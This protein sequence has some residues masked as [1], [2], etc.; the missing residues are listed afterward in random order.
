[1][2]SLPVNI[3]FSYASSA[4][5]DTFLFDALKKHLTLLKSLGYVNVWYDSAIAAGSNWQK[6]VDNYLDTA[7]IIVLLFSADFLAS[8]HC[9]EVEMKRALE[10]RE[11]GVARVIY[12]LLRPVDWSELSLDSAGFLPPGGNPISLWPDMDSALMEVVKGIKKVV[13]ELTDR[14][15]NTLARGPK[16][17]LSNL[18]YRQN[19][20]F[21]GREELLTSIHS[22]FSAYARHTRIQALNGLAGIGKTEIAIEYAYRYP[23]EY[24]AIFWIRASSLELF[25]TD[26]QAL[27]DLLLLPEKERTSERKLFAAIQRYLQSSEGWLLF[28]DDLEDFRLID[29]LIPLQCKGHVLLTSRIQ[30]KHRSVHALSVAPMTM[31]E[32]ALFLL[33][34]IKLI[35]E[36][37]G[38]DVALPDDYLHA[39][40]VA[41]ALDGFPLVLDQAGAYIEDTE[42][43]LSHYLT[44]YRT[45]QA[46]LL[47][48]RGQSSESHPESVTATLDLAFEQVR[49]VNPLA[50]QLLYLFAFLHFDAIPD[51]MLIQGGIELDEPLKALALDPLALDAALATL[52][53]FSLVHGRTDTTL[54]RIHRIV[55]AVL[56]DSLSADQQRYWVTMAVRLV[57]R[58]FPGSGFPAWPLYQRYLAQAQCCVTFITEFQLVDLA[59]AQLAQRLG[60]Y[61]SKRALYDEARSYLTLAIDLYERIS[62]L[63]S[64]DIARALV[65]QGFLFYKLGDYTQS[66]MLYL[67][68]LAI[69]GQMLEPEEQNT[70]ILLNNLAL[71]YREQNRYQEAEVLYQ[72]VLALYRQIFGPQHS[73]VATVLNNLA[74]LYQKQNRYQ[75]AEELYLQALVQR[76]ATLQAGNPNLAQSWNNLATLYQMQGRYQEAKPLLQRALALY[77][78]TMGFEHPDTAASLNNLAIL[79]SALGDY[80]QARDLHLRELA[81]YEQ[82]FGLEHSDTAF[83]LNN[84][85]KIYRLQ[86]ND[87]QAEASYLQ[88][89]AIYER[90]LG[91]DHPDRALPLNNLGKLYLLQHRYSQAESLLLQAVAIAE[92]GL[93]PEHLQT[94]WYS[95]NLAELYTYQ[96]K[97]EE[98]ELLY[99]RALAGY[100]QILGLENPDTVQIAEK[101]AKLYEVT[102]RIEKAVALR[103]T[104]MQ[105]IKE[106]GKKGY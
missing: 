35:P 63:E 60:E 79:F 19:L 84:L 15:V 77:E 27:A 50:M 36:Q 61:C 17:F 20:F 69:Y 13:D 49:K 37:A 73:E 59:A 71:L 11:L 10:R 106:R 1:M 99:Q 41:Q 32:S 90:T 74:L 26:V 48:Q 23:Q 57:N 14:V 39:L 33:R 3:F 43:D 101:F 34:R 98:A 54:L 81:I 75:E 47:Q 4:D 68:A 76:E 66:E 91:P 53:G 30:I 45:H 94:L 80:E 25:H 16:K 52:L 82:T 95:S 55:Q 9:R 6:I 105:A 44:L 83:T 24:Q 8:D 28:F 22:Y 100:Q 5:K 65:S 31:D 92:R 40:A 88:A 86:N 87:P 2:F 72:R 38:L 7:D 70:G 104:I 56:R 93:G 103:Q 78:Q 29:L 85:G 42:S 67:R 62:G 12:V 89:I 21:T 97:Y 102:A 96:G 64:L 51:E 46:Y 58:V 18:P